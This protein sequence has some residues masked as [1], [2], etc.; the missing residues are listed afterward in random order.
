MNMIDLFNMELYTERS[1]KYTDLLEIIL[2][3]LTRLGDYVNDDASFDTK[4]VH[5]HYLT[6]LPFLLHIGKKGNITPWF[7]KSEMQAFSFDQH[8]DTLIEEL[9][10]ELSMF[11]RSR[12][13]EDTYKRIIHLYLDIGLL[14]GL[15]PKR[16]QSM[17][18]SNSK[19]KANFKR[20]LYN[21]RLAKLLGNGL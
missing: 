21:Q 8:V 10:S 19:Y 5:D 3:R 9:A 15:T 14:L 7:V 1:L 17:Y 2:K 4:V 20:E 13:K 18:E 16:I 11:T 12:K 6:I